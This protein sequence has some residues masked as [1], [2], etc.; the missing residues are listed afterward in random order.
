[1]NPLLS[2]TRGVLAAPVVAVSM[3]A[4]LAPVSSAVQTVTIGNGV[5]QAAFEQTSSPT[6]FFL[7]EVERFNGATPASSFEFDQESLWSVEFLGGYTLTS[8]NTVGTVDV[9]LI[10][11]TSP[12]RARVTWL[13]RV[14]VATIPGWTGTFDVVL[15]FHIVDGTAEIPDSLEVDASFEFD[16]VDLTPL[17]LTAPRLSIVTDQS[18]E[19]TDMRLFVPRWG[20]RLYDNPAESQ[21]NFTP[22][23]GVPLA[24]G[25]GQLRFAYPSAASMQWFALYREVPVPALKQ[26]ALEY[27]EQLE[28]QLDEPLLQFGTRDTGLNFKYYTLLSNFNSGWDRDGSFLFEVE[29]VPHLESGQPNAA[30]SQEFVFPFP[31]FLTP[32]HGDWWRGAEIYREW[33]HTSGVAWLP[34]HPLGSPSSTASSIA[35]EARAFGTVGPRNCDQ[36][37]VNPSTGSGPCIPCAASIPFGGPDKAMFSNWLA[38]SQDL[39][40]VLGLAAT[41]GRF[42][43]RV[44]GWEQNSFDANWGEYEP[45]P[46]SSDGLGGSHPGTYAT[47]AS[48]VA[49]AG[50]KFMNYYN[51]DAIR[52]TAPPWYGG[53]APWTGSNQISLQTGSLLP[54]LDCA[55]LPSAPCSDSLEYFGLDHSYID[56]R[57]EYI[58]G[59]TRDI[60]HAPISTPD[61]RSQL[62]VDWTKYGLDVVSSPAPAPPGRASG[63]LGL[64]LDAFANTV[65]DSWGD[66]Y[67]QGRIVAAASAIDYATTPTI[68]GGLGLP[69]Y[70]LGSESPS[71]ALLGVLEWGMIH[72]NAVNSVPGDSRL[73]PGFEAVYNDYFRSHDQSLL[74]VPADAQ[75]QIASPFWMIWARKLHATFLQLG[76]EPATGMVL[77]NFD[78]G[79]DV[80]LPLTASGLAALHPT[81]YGT[82]LD[83]VARS[84]HVI[85]DEDVFAHVGVGTLVRPPS[86]FTD[87]GYPNDTSDFTAVD[88]AWPNAYTPEAN[89]VMVVAHSRDDY[90]TGGKSLCILLANWTDSADATVDLDPSGSTLFL[91]NPGD[92]TVALWIDLSQWSMPA[93]VGYDVFIV[94]PGTTFGTADKVQVASDVTLP[95]M[96]FVVPWNVPE[97]TCHAILVIPHE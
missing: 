26:P 40:S 8:Q 70:C 97:L 42:V 68:S 29:Q 30:G 16:D 65:P 22:P 6:D 17:K 2:R 31:S 9:R 27:V 18:E 38:Q 35:R 75:P 80:G 82:Y 61:P 5:V 37:H 32:T 54:T 92:Q 15:D 53:V 39:A 55:S 45:V 89:N 44:V 79:P 58:C 14:P 63:S 43:Q 50:F 77:D 13:D 7:R 23:P 85:N 24:P 41:P 4:A 66:A 90:A 81:T 49:G 59:A 86:Y 78:S 28:T 84:V 71:E 67:V 12:T 48:A 19:G 96:G 95:G 62:A 46:G 69:D 88:G 93:N 1:M 10:P 25:V 83:F 56:D 51:T 36:V 74:L 34:A 64:Y 21:F 33:V 91:N 20:G 60:L 52:H 3:F 47:A 87:T 57:E 72:F 73:V 94:Q 11:L 76:Y